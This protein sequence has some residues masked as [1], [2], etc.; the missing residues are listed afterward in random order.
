MRSVVSKNRQYGLGWTPLGDNEE[1]C[2]RF[3]HLHVA[4][5]VCGCK[6]RGG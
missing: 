4:R 3:V 2:L 5:C 1:D 6:G